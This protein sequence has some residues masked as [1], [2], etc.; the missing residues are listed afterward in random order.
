MCNTALE[1]IYTDL[2]I[3]YY[4]TYCITYITFVHLSY[5]YYRSYYRTYY[6]FIKSLRRHVN[7]YV[8][9]TLT[10]EFDWLPFK[11]IASPCLRLFSLLYFE[12]HFQMITFLY[13]HWLL[14]MYHWYTGGYFNSWF[15]LIQPKCA[16]CVFYTCHCPFIQLQ[17]ICI[18]I[19][20]ALICHKTCQSFNAHICSCSYI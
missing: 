20:L 17:N 8:H 9:F 12:Y 15:Q 16:C 3:Y 2:L 7:M 19:V 13:G 4:I 5:S 6:T 18:F 1:T 11:Q 14:H 10:L